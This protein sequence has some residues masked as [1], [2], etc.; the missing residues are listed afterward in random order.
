M[1]RK[2]GKDPIKALPDLLH[3]HCYGLVRVLRV[4]VVYQKI[5]GIGYV[6][7]VHHSM[8]DEVLQKQILT[9]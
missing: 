1:M 8:L 2:I 7:L 5:Q 9:N 3:R 4:E 6:A